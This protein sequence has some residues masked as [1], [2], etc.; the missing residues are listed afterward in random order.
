MAHEDIIKSLDNIR[1]QDQENET[2]I[3]ELAVKTIKALEAYATPRP[4]GDGEP[5]EITPAEYVGLICDLLGAADP[6]SMEKIYISASD[7]NARAYRKA[8]KA[9]EEAEARERTRRAMAGFIGRYSAA[10]EAQGMSEA[11]AKIRAIEEYNR[12][13]YD[14]C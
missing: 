13:K 1:A 6:A 14:I 5:Q 7:I 12:L 4:A 10:L 2:T 9:Q 3:Y 11:E 8:R